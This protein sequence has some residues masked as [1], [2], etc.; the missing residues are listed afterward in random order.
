MCL[1]DYSTDIETNT[2]MR[3]NHWNRN[4]VIALKFCEVTLLRRLIQ[5]SALWQEFRF[6]LIKITKN[7]SSFNFLIHQFARW[8]NVLLNIAD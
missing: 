1:F 4:N 2:D 7:W 8:Q 5:F 3:S 6:A